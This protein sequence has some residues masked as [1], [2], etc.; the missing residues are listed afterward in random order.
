M[1]SYKT[2]ETEKQWAVPWCQIAEDMTNLHISPCQSFP[3]RAG[4]RSRDPITI[5]YRDTP[6]V[7]NDDE[8]QKVA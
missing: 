1:R 2:A 8:K 3:Q 7:L 6:D 5:S 4:Q